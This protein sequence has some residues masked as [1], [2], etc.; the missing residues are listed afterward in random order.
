VVDSDVKKKPVI[1]TSSKWRTAIISELGFWPNSADFLPVLYHDVTALPYNKDTVLEG[2]HWAWLQRWL[3]RTV[4]CTQALLQR[5]LV[6]PDE[7]VDVVCLQA[8]LFSVSVVRLEWK[9]LV[10]ARCVSLQQELLVG[11]VVCGI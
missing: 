4:W 5:W 9:M 10:L 1:D 8:C 3:R 6:G 11:W 7:D 2:I